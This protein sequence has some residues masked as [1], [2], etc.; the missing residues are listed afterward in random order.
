MNVELYI[1]EASDQAQPILRK[2]RAMARAQH[3]DAEETISYKL[4]AFKKGRVFLYFAAFKR[5]IGICLHVEA[6]ASLVKNSSPIVTQK[7][8]CNSPMTDTCLMI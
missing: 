8:I 6:P 7:A 3:P 2:I 5:H 1:S 4:P